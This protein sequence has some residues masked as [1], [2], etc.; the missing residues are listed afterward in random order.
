[1]SLGTGKS[2]CLGGTEGMVRD[3]EAERP[4]KWVELDT[5]CP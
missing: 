5:G 1:M 2:M 3:T 4:E